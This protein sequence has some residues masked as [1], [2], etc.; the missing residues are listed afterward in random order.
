MPFSSGRIATARSRR[1]ITT[2]DSAAMPDAAMASRSTTYTSWPAS[3]SG[4]M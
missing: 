1:E 2:R 3:P 4:T